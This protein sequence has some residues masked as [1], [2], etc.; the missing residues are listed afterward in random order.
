MRRGKPT[1][2]PK[3]NPFNFLAGPAG[4]ARLTWSSFYSPDR[5]QL[6]PPNA[7]SKFCQLSYWKCTP[8]LL[9]GSSWTLKISRQDEKALLSITSFYDPQ[10]E[11]TTGEI[12]S[13]CSLFWF[14][15]HAGTCVQWSWGKGNTRR[16][17]EVSFTS[18][19]RQ[20]WD[21][22]NSRSYIFKYILPKSSNHGPLGPRTYRAPP[23]KNSARATRIPSYQLHYGNHPIMRSSRFRHS[24]CTNHLAASQALAW[25]ELSS[26]KNRFPSWSTDAEYYAQGYEVTMDKSIS[27]CSASVSDCVWGTR[28]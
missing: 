6:L 10:L 17:P 16:K 24:I 22:P 12:G 19:S 4:T 15:D 13:L 27:T 9:L 18:Y 23:Q 28:L 11:I 3:V 1:S 2:P 20:F 14:A 5:L 25:D 26:L 21:N 8:L 7:G